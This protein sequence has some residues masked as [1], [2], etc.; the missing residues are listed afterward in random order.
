[1]VAKSENIENGD[2]F[3]VNKDMANPKTY[4]EP[5]VDMIDVSK[6][7][8]LTLNDVDAKVKQGDPAWKKKEKL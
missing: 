7:L 6:E 2:E 3:A 8:N 1:M 4:K 5:G